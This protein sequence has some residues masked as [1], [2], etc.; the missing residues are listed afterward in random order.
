[1]FKYLAAVLALVAGSVVCST[2]AQADD[3]MAMPSD[4]YRVA[5]NSSVNDLDSVATTARDEDNS[6]GSTRAT[7]VSGD[8][9]A[10]DA[11][12]P[13]RAPVNNALARPIHA[14][15]AHQATA[16]EHTAA[17]GTA[18]IPKNP[19]SVR[20]QSLLPGVMK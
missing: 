2:I 7:I 19:A 15:P 11:P 6:V 3:M 12:S 8:D 9:D 5:S 17:P 16:A 10:G 14:S 18:N 13:T 20:W 1:M 4:G